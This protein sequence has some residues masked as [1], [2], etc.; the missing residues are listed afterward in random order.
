VLTTKTRRRFNK[1]LRAFCRENG[2]R[3]YASPKLGVIVVWSRKAFIPTYELRWHR[4]RYHVKVFID[5]DVMRS[6]FKLNTPPKLAR[7]IAFLG[8]WMELR[9]GI[10]DV[11]TTN[12]D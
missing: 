6:Q 5:D 10:H 2:L 11:M 9:C 3:H 7:F 4:D 1:A 12:A 8:A